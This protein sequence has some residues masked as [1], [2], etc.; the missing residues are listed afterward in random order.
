[1]TPTS[2]FVMRADPTPKKKRPKV[3]FV[4]INLDSYPDEPSVVRKGSV[5]PV[6]GNCTPSEARRIAAA[7]N[8]HTSYLKGEL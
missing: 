1:M 5:I 3:R 2:A 6:C 4:A 7:L 8:F